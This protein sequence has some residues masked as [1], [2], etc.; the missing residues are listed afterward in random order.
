MALYKC[1]ECGNDVSTQAISCPK[2]GCVFKK[3]DHV[4]ITAPES[5]PQAKRQETPIGIII[6]I[7]LCGLSIV[8]E[9]F[10]NV[11]QDNFWDSIMVFTSIA[12]IGAILFCISQLVFFGAN[13]A[14]III[15]IF[16]IQG[17]YQYSPKLKQFA[18]MCIRMCVLGIL[19]TYLGGLLYSPTMLDLFGLK[20][21]LNTSS[22][23]ALKKLGEAIDQEL[24][25]S[26]YERYEMRWGDSR[27]R[28]DVNKTKI[29]GVTKK[30]ADTF[31]FGFLS[32]V[33]I[34]Y[35]L[36]L[37]QW[38]IILKAAPSDG[39]EPRGLGCFKPAPNSFLGLILDRLGL[40][41]FM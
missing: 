23:S 39:R 27:A 12:T 22:D 14:C 5:L 38:V 35:L 15:A 26:E 19:S 13:I 24:S 6:I 41:R 20:K 34:N 33:G 40:S 28:D 2:C 1:P 36:I 17:N 32:V 4:N 31:A 18:K 8:A 7:V 10:F 29:E 37:I 11:R 9:I 16:S 30:V 25:Y 21:V 3:A